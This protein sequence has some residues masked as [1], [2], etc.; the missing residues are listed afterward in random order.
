ADVTEPLAVFG[1]CLAFWF[2]AIPTLSLGSALAFRQLRH[3][4]RDFGKVRLWGTVG[5]MS[6]SLLLGLWLSHEATAATADLADSMRL[7]AIFA[8]L[9]AAYAPTLPHTPPQPLRA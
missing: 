8:L 7:G 4:E 3:P 5:W 1:A 9:V 6:A 2:F